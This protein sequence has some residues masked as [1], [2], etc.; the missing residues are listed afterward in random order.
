[1]RARRGRATKGQTGRPRKAVAATGN[2][3]GVERQ[4]EEE[5]ARGGGVEEGRPPTPE[6]KLLELLNHKNVFETAAAASAGLR[7]SDTRKS[8]YEWLYKIAEE[9]LTAGQSSGKRTCFCSC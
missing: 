1:M 9:T 2:L 7:N 3:V 4:G 5:E 6:K 8:R